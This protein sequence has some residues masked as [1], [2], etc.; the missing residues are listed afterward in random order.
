MKK[1]IKSFSIVL[2]SNIVSFIITALVTFIVPKQLNVEN[3]GYFQLYLFYI[4]YIG[5]LHFGWADGI[6]LRYG[7]KY[8]ETLNKS[9]FK[10]QIYLFSIVEIILAFALVLVSIFTVEVVDREVVCIFTG[11]AIIL[12]LPRTFL[13]Y[14]LQCTNRLKE[15]A[16][17]TIIE[18]IFYLLIVLLALSMRGDSF[19]PLLIADVIGKAVA[20]CYSIYQCRDIFTAKI[21]RIKDIIKESLDNIRVGIKLMFA[22]IAASLIIGIVRFS[23]ERQWDVATFGKISLTMS[24]SSLLMV[25]IRAVSTVVFPLICRSENQKIVAYYNVLKT[26]VMMP[27]LGMLVL[28]YPIKEILSIWLPQYSDSLNYMAL[29]FPMCIYESKMSMLIET[30]MKALR[31]EKWLL[32]INLITVILSCILTCASVYILHNLNLAVLTIVVV[33]AFRCILAEISVS[34]IL[35]IS[36]MQDIVIETLLTIVFIFSSWYIGGFLGVIVYTM[37]Y[38]IYLYIKRNDIKWMY[39]QLRLHIR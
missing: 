31:K 14:I 37:F 21:A 18:K 13:Q 27:L 30:Y 22:N 19:L 33:L 4:G 1:I 2:I 23:I 7:G 8:Y 39:K 24:V 35:D 25:F 26:L 11:V 12:L 32:S 16:F 38:C 20:L 5:F 36:N 29:L 6:L 34:M 10:G 9:L 15:C 17:Q 28:Y 3:Y